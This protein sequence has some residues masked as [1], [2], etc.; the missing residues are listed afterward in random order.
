[1]S[2]A[3]IPNTPARRRFLRNSSAALLGLLSVDGCRAVASTTTAG[4]AAPAR[5]TDVLVVGSGIAG[6]CAAIE[7]ADAGAEV[8]VLE[9][10]VQPGGCAKFS[11]G[12]ITVAGTH[13]QA[14]AGIKDHPDW[15]FRDMMDDG[16]MIAV[17]ELIRAYVDAGPEHVVWLEK[18]GI[19]FAKQFQDDSNTDRVRPGVAR[20]HMIAASPEYPGRPHR[21]GL[22]L[23]SML[24]RAA[25][26][27]GVTLLLEYKMTRLLRDGL[28]GPVTGA[29]VESRGSVF[30]IGARRAV[31]VASGGWS[32]NL[33]MAAAEDPRL[34]EDIYPDCWPY[35]LCLG[36]GHIAAVDVG[37]ELSNMAYGGYLVPRWGSRVYQIWEPPVMTNLPR[38]NT[39]V[40]IAD[41]RHVI[42]VDGEGKRFVNEI[43]GNPKGVPL[44]GNSKFSYTPGSFPSHPFIQ[45]YL[46]L[47][48]RPRNVWAMTD[49]EGAAALGWL[50]NV[51]ELR[52]PDPKSGLALY[53]EMVAIGDSLG[54]VARKADLP[55]EALEATIRRYN[56]MVASGAD[57]DFQKLP[58]GNAIAGPPFY[59][60]RMALVK[61]TR[62]NGIRA[63]T[64]AAVL[65][66]AGL[67]HSDTIALDQQVTIPRLYA[68]GEC[69]NY[70]GRSHGHGTLGIYSYFGR[71]AGKSAAAES[72]AS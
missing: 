2:E 8:I 44:E 57:V 39:G 46:N 30:S 11:G 23:M 50:E 68:A 45:A 15:L 60:V 33:P 4:A 29:E 21:G 51:E 43:L 54:D 56:A 52:R 22:G 66:R 5:E 28:Q 49:A 63:N 3:S 34:T 13:L 58:L 40:S 17:P 26:R 38:I 18:L 62:R 47:P 27:K 71:I 7:A 1:M 64:R 59:A 19:R 12:H 37:A 69:V 36:E 70:L 65:E 35:H 55:A 42:L 6:I 24:L 9:K 10:D 16:E 72:R 53:P 31:I 67:L 41:F 25:R 14:E 48:A 32:G 61:H 20:G